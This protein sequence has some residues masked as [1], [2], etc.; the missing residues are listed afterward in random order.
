MGSPILDD[1][2]GRILRIFE[3]NWAGL[4]EMGVT[5]KICAVVDCQ[6]WCG[7]L[8][9]ELPPSFQNPHSP[10]GWDRWYR[11][12][13]CCRRGPFV[14]PTNRA[15]E[16][17]DCPT[18]SISAWS[19]TGI[20]HRQPMYHADALLAMLPPVSCSIGIGEALTCMSPTC[21]ALSGHKAKIDGTEGNLGSAI[22]LPIYLPSNCT[23]FAQ[24][25]V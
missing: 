5:D 22:Y 25:A 3:L 6:R 17:T 23:V 1:D 20:F 10:P 8:G 12:C 9:D 7:E 13:V 4:A 24:F 16:D 19:P 21:P 2:A 14:R 11:Y 15:K 18:M